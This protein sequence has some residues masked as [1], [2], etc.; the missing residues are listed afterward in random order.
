MNFQTVKEIRIS[1]FFWQRFVDPLFALPLHNA[2]DPHLQKGWRPG[3]SAITAADAY[4]KQVWIWI[5]QEFGNQ[6]RPFVDNEHK[7]EFEDQFALN[8]SYNVP[9][10]ADNHITGGE[11][12]IIYGFNGVIN[13]TFPDENT[14]WQIV[15]LAPLAGIFLDELWTIMISD[16][17][18]SIITPDLARPLGEFYII[19]GGMKAVH[20]PGS[21]ILTKNILA[22]LTFKYAANYNRTPEQDEHILVFQI[23]NYA[24]N[25]V[26][27]VEADVKSLT[28]LQRDEIDR[29]ILDL[30]YF[31]SD[32]YQYILDVPSNSWPFYRILV[33]NNIWQLHRIIPD[34]LRRM[35]PWPD[36]PFHVPVPIDQDFFPWARKQAEKRAAT[37]K[38]TITLTDEQRAAAVDLILGGDRYL[39]Q[40]IFTPSLTRQDFPANYALSPSILGTSSEGVATTQLDSTQDKPART[41]P[42]IALLAAGGVLALLLSRGGEK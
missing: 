25:M 26:A 4:F 34:E 30:Y 37:M 19:E 18:L 12:G 13:T 33:Q 21:D 23:A 5:A 22:W 6:I 11:K 15:A 10:D 27:Q 28:P 40:T 36:F 3:G 16:R 42:M 20:L 32:L 2:Y 31:E 41:S 9:V 29:M 24:D 17:Y 14:F 38:T 8:L 1:M 39:G 7:D 35:I